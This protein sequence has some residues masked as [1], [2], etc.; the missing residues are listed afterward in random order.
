MK[1]LKMLCVVCRI[2]LIFIDKEL[3]IT[4]F[5]TICAPYFKKISPK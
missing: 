1:T 3:C 5:V 4:E 2:P